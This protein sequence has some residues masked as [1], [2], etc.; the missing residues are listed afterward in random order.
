MC[1][2]Y[3]VF[4]SILI[5]VKETGCIFQSELHSS[6]PHNNNR[7]ANSYSKLYYIIQLLKLTLQVVSLCFV[8]AAN[9]VVN[10][11]LCSRHYHIL[12]TSSLI[13]SNL[14]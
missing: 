12:L 4:D 13:V 10:P 2:P 1:G 3:T 6:E 14:G 7:Q 8:T 11:F 9:E 5:N